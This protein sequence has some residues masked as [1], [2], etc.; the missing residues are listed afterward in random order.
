M[1]MYLILIAQRQTKKSDT[2][3]L[4]FIMIFRLFRILLFLI[5]NIFVHDLLGIRKFT[6]TY[7]YN[8]R[9]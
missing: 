7:I 4:L 1:I 5:Y 8:K 2:Y 6:V 3:T 9:Q